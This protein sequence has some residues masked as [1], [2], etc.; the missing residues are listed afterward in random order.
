MIGEQTESALARI[1]AAL[2]RIERGSTRLAAATAQ[3]AEHHARL[4]AE[5]DDRHAR[6][7]QAVAEAMRKLD[8][9]IGRAG[10]AL[11]VT[12]QTAE[13]PAA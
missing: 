9:L 4:T 7:R 13:D 10:S 11:A 2:A 12:G 6:L 1:E 5:Q 8:G 3:Q